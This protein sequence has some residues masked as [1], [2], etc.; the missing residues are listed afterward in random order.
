MKKES[1]RLKAKKSDFL[2]EVGFLGETGKKGLFLACNHYGRSIQ[3]LSKKYCD[4]FAFKYNKKYNSNAYQTSTP[5]TSFYVY[6]QKITI[7]GVFYRI[8]NI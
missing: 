4:V 1:N 8:L 2:Y 3:I 6:K 5:E 7:V